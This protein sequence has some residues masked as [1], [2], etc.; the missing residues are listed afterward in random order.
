MDHHHTTDT[1]GWAAFDAVVVLSLAGAAA[2]YAVALWAA[3]DRSPW[4]AS[5]T[6]VWYAGLAC[7]AAGLTGPVATAAHTSFTAHMAAHLL[8][9]MVAP[10]L[11]VLGAPVTLI[12]RALPVAAARALTSLLRTLVVR[13]V[14]HPVVAGVLNAGGLWVLYTTD[15]FPL[16][17]TSEL[18][19]GLVHAHLLMAGYLFTASLIGVD[20]N[21]HRA[22][23]QVR[24]AVLILFIAAHSTLAKRLYAHPPA[25]V[26]A[27]DGRFGAQLMYYGGD[28]VDVTVI[29]LLFTGW[30]AATRPRTGRDAG[31]VL[32]QP[33]P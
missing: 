16:M 20:P 5:R 23:V 28:V 18:V 25:G 31:P 22:S 11:L 32:S 17:H 4:A 3:R 19:H 29:V 8:V 26:D 7:A 1:A 30:Y 9:G 10:L 6:V 33:S 12:L 13:V 27:A 2:G 24:A 14:T 21:P 15:L